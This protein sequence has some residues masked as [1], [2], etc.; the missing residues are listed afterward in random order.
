M[1]DSHRRLLLPVCPE[2]LGGLGTPREPMSIVDGYGEDVLEGRA[3]VV[4]E[5]RRDVT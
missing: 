3:M 5:C 2:Q 4:D 1:Q